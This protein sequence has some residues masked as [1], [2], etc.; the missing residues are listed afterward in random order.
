VGR[1]CDWKI[2]PLALGQIESAAESVGQDQSEAVVS[3]G[4]D[5]SKDVGK[6]E[7]FV[8]EARCALA[9][10]PPDMASPT[11]LADPR[12][13]LKKQADALIFMRILNFSEQRRG[14]F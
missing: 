11:L 4:L 8:A 3:A 14:S 1:N 6:G 12:L 13:V 10:L 7:A 5:A 2:R 9:A